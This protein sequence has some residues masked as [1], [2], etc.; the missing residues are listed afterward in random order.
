MTLHGYDLEGITLDDCLMQRARLKNVDLSGVRI[1]GS[2]LVDVEI[3]GEIQNLIVNGVD[4][5]PLV[6]AE[7]DR[8]DPERT[9]MHPTDAAGF[10]EAWDIIERR[11]AETVERARDLD[12]EQLHER[13]DGEWSFIETLRHLVFATDA[14]VRRALL[15]D[16]SPYSPLDLPH[17]DMAAAPGVVPNDADARPTLE[18]ML[19]LRR[20][21][22]ASMRRVVDE[23]TDE[24][25][26][27]HT[28][29]VEGPGYPSPRS[30][31]V[32][33]VLETILNEEWMHRQYA[34]RDLAVL[35]R[36]KA[37]LTEETRATTGGGAI[38]SRRAIDP[39]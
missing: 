28:T 3:D 25:L 22:M 29:V 26:A 38:G 37:A 18:E 5:A 39:D 24:Q 30:F 31:P 14:W 21:R 27:G 13:V 1:R 23:L 17:E 7:L 35:E 19:E 20:D 9:K 33:G 6:E 8:R 2:M 12:A 15:G 16:P 4:V 10:R 36:R 11:W 34:E 32:A